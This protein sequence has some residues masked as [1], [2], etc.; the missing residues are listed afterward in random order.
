L[1]AALQRVIARLPDQTP[2][3][4]STDQLSV[5]ERMASILDELSVH[6]SLDFFRLCAGAPSR[7]FVIVTFLAVLELVKMQLMVV[8]TTGDHDQ[9]LLQLASSA[10]VSEDNERRAAMEIEP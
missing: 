1:V 3:V 9:V 2:F 5:N 6:S 10:F 8:Q 7:L 4:I